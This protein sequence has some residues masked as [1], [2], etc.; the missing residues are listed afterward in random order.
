L[1]RRERRGAPRRRG[2]DGLRPSSSS[3]T[4]RR[5]FRPWMRSDRFVARIRR[6]AAPRRLRRRECGVR[7]RGPPSGASAVSP[8]VSGRC[9]CR[10]PAPHAGHTTGSAEAPSTSL[11]SFGPRRD[12]VRR[13]VHPRGRHTH[14][15]PDIVASREALEKASARPAAAL[16]NCPWSTTPPDGLDS[17]TMRDCQRSMD[18]RQYPGWTWTRDRERRTAATARAPLAPH[19]DARPPRGQQVV[20]ALRSAIVA[21]RY[22]PGERLI[23]TSLS[24]S[25]ARAAALSARR[26]G[27]S[28]TRAS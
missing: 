26:S 2:G 3:F 20:E 25:S 5:R 18:C 14:A 7:L 17:A 13:R 12:R 27:S 8:P 9:T 6:P 19:A 4:R 11:R 1:A 24:R 21:G 10:T 23:E 15:V 28:R 22:E 16:P